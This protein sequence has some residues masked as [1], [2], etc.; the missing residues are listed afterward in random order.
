MSEEHEEDGVQFE[1]CMWFFMLYL[2]LKYFLLFGMR[3]YCVVV[4]GHTIF[5]VQG[6]KGEAV[7]YT[8]DAEEDE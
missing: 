8:F 5:L 2:L 1:W 3:G 4:D 6:W 7:I